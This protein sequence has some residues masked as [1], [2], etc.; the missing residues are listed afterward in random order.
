MFLDTLALVLI[1]IPL[2][3]KISRDCL[4]SMQPMLH[5]L[6]QHMMMLSLQQHMLA[7]ILYQIP[8]ANFLLFVCGW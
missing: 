4:P 8:P 2:V 3:V 6:S 7:L 5:P 1:A